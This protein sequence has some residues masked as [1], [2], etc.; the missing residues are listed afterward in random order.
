MTLRAS[1][2]NSGVNPVAYDGQFIGLADA[3]IVQLARPFFDQ[4]NPK[5]T[6]PGTQQILRLVRCWP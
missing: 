2:Y 6:G 4:R 3:L 5:S 1:Q